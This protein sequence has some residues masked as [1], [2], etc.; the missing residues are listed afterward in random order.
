MVFFCSVA[1]RHRFESI[2]E[3]ECGCGSATIEYWKIILMALWRR[4]I[5]LYWPVVLCDGWIYEHWTVSCSSSNQDSYMPRAVALP[6]SLLSHYYV[7]NYEWAYGLSSC[8]GSKLWL[9]IIW[10]QI[11]RSVQTLVTT[12]HVFRIYMSKSFCLI[13][14]RFWMIVDNF[15]YK[16]TRKQKMDAHKTPINLTQSIGSGNLIKGMLGVTTELGYYKPSVS[17]KNTQILDKLI[18]KYY[19]NTSCHTT[20]WLDIKH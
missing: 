10:Q 18:R 8:Y 1:N 13:S 6:A 7:I 12:R 20:R 3:I 11:R 4:T 16:K 14:L 17:W 5:W 9:H 2:G 19:Y 15:C